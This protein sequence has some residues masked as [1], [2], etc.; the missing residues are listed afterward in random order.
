MSYII[1]Y[2]EENR[3]NTGMEKDL[4]NNAEAVYN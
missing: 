4:K 1:F 2:I 3:G